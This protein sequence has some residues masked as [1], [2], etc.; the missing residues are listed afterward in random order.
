MVLAIDFDGTVVSQA[1]AYEDL[2][3]PLQFLPGA[4]HALLSLKKA[5]HLLVLWSA[6]SSPALLVNPLLDPLVRVGVKTVDLE[7]WD[8]MLPVHRARQRQML[9]FVGRE[10]PGVFAAIDDGAAGK[11]PG[12]DL[13]IDDRVLR[14]GQ[15]TGGFGWDAVADMYGSPVYGAEEVA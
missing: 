9:D 5:G 3:T 1:R 15:G 12:V 11:L 4:R 13:F 10:L 7:R 6:R 2:E 14:L 8:D